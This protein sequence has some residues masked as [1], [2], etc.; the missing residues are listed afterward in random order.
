MKYNIKVIMNNKMGDSLTASELSDYEESVIKSIQKIIEETNIFPVK[1]D[2][3]ITI[4][5]LENDC[6]KILGRF[7]NPNDCSITYEF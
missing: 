2:W 7:I 1:G 3:I 6:S 5:Q 4:F